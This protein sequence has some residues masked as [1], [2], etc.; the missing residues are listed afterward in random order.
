MSDRAIARQSEISLDRFSELF[1]GR[2]IY[3][4]LIPVVEYVYQG[5]WVVK[6]LPL[7]VNLR[8]CPKMYYFTQIYY[9]FLLNREVEW[10][11]QYILAPNYSHSYPIVY[12][13]CYKQPGTALCLVLKGE[14]DLLFYNRFFSLQ[15]SLAIVLLFVCVCSHPIDCKKHS[16]A[17]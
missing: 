1:I 4:S 16:A 17:V 7:L 8:S 10:N 11:R 9:S 12:P 15:Q 13:T 5:D 2:Y 3:R 14:D 6:N